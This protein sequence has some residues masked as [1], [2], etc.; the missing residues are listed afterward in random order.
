MF[1][2]VKKIHASHQKPKPFL[3]GLKEVIKAVT[4]EKF[5]FWV[6]YLLSDGIN[7]AFFFMTFPL[8]LSDPTFV[9]WVV[10]TYG[11][12]F[13]ICSQVS[14]KLL[15]RTYWYLVL[16]L[17]LILAISGYVC[18]YFGVQTQHIALFFVSAACFGSME[19]LQVITG[20]TIAIKV[21]PEDIMA[22]GIAAYRTGSSLGMII[23]II[24]E[25]NIKWSSS[26]I[27]NSSVLLFACLTIF[28]GICTS[29]YS[30]L[31]PLLPQSIAAP[32]PIG[33][34]PIRIMNG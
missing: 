25:L 19:S 29:P 20:T 27:V 11:L 23:G 34:A 33:I 4:H 32:K 16:V 18:V 30:A 24:I 3:E 28:V 5:G 6:P 2:F 15:D 17:D 26:I 31:I 21:L 9:N 7:Q 12:C 8:L 14:G 13:L 10:L 1:L 22:G